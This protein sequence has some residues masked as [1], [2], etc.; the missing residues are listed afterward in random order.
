MK[1]STKGNVNEGGYSFYQNVTKMLQV[2]MTF[3][4]TENT[5]RHSVGISLCA[6]DR[7]A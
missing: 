4:K 3:E 1:G 7:N 2:G 6:A 5:I